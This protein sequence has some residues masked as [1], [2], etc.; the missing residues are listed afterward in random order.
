MKAT[1]ELCNK[2]MTFLSLSLIILTL[3]FDVKRFM[4]IGFIFG[5]ITARIVMKKFVVQLDNLKSMELPNPN[6]ILNIFVY[7]FL[8]TVMGMIDLV[9]M[10]SSFVSLMLYRK[11][12]FILVEKNKKEGGFDGNNY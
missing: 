9:A 10:L 2:I 5:Y 12:F 7:G 1:L 6:L 4:A 11:L 8:L 3:L